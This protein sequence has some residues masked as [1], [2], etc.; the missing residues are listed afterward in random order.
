MYH[1]YEKYPELELVEKSGHHRLDVRKGVLRHAPRNSIGAEIGVFTGLFSDVLA[2]EIPSER[3][4]LV[5]PWSK[6]HGSHFPDW[7]HYSANIALSTEVAKEAALWRAKTAHSE[8]IIVEDFST[9]WLNRFSKPFLGWV[10]LD[11][12]HSYE[13]VMEDLFAIEKCLLP[14]G[15]IMGDDM[16][17]P[18][19]QGI[20]AVYFAVRTFCQKM[21]FD[22]IHI[23]QHGQWAIKRTATIDS[24]AASFA[25]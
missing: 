3:I 5:D 9:D 23:D 8:C 7:G 22:V 13:A 6:L 1:L 15:T 16:W 10:Y 20:S 19:K 18:G 17:I 24:L 12:K 14:D 2:E 21:G 25:E 4:Y 11:A